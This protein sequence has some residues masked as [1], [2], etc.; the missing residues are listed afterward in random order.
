MGQTNFIVSLLFLGAVVALWSRRWILDALIDGIDEI[1][2]NFPGGPPT[3][4]HPSPADDGKL[5]RR[6]SRKPANGG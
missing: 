4:M 5:L 2:N 1:A 6:R 3:P